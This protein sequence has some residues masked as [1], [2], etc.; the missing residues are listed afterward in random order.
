MDWADFVPWVEDGVNGRLERLYARVP[1]RRVKVRLPRRRGT[2][3]RRDQE[4]DH[5]RCGGSRRLECRED[6]GSRDPVG[7]S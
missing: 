6:N 1:N 2:Q 3:E 7:G 5:E 4:Q